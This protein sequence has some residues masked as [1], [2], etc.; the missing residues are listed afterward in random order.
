LTDGPVQL[1]IDFAEVA[2]LYPEFHAAVRINRYEFGVTKI[3]VA[4][5]YLST[6]RS[7]SHRPSPAATRD[8]RRPPAMD[9]SDGCAGRPG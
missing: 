3:K 8:V 4:G 9:R 6:C 5:R 7:T 2:G 1:T